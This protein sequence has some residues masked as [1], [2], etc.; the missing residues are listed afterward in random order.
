MHLG[1]GEQPCLSEVLI[2]EALQGAWFRLSALGCG[3]A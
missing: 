2:V 3:L 1:L